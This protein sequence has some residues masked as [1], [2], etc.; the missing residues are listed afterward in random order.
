VDDIIF[1]GSS[2][3]LVSRFQEIMESEFQMSMMGELTFF[4]GIQV[5][6][7]KQGTFVHQA[8]YMNDLMKKFNMAELKSVSTPM[9]SAASLGSD[10]D[11][12]VV[13]QREYRSMIGSLMYLTATRLDIQFIM[14]MCACF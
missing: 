13:D 4:L 12:E 5:K 11:G 1:G 9:S 3:T 7:T 14:G 6:Q 2:H 8:K 10:E